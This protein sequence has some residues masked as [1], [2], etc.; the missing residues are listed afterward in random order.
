MIK[1]CN[2]PKCQG[3]FKHMN[4]K[5]FAKLLA[6]AYVKFGNSIDADV[7]TTNDK[8]SLFIL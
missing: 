6:I 1:S 5:K 2:Q 8:N 7:D 4:L 3:H